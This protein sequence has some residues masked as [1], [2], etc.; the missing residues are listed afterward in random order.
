[1]FEV[2]VELLITRIAVV[3]IKFQSQRI[4]YTYYC[5]ELL[6]I[7]TRGTMVAPSPPTTRVGR[8]NRRSAYV[9]V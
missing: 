9:C 7:Y 4:S 2:P 5:R 8:R 3:V 6:I 1:M